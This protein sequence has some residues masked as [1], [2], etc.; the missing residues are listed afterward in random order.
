[1]K[2]L[3]IIP[4]RSGSKGLKDKN[5]KPLNGIP[6][7]A[8]TIKAAVDSGIFA[9]IHFSTD[10]QTYADIA[11]KYGAS[12]PFL[13]D[14]ILANDTASSWD[15]VK[16]VIANSQKLGKSFDAVM[17][18]QP[19]VPF[20]T[21]EDIRNAL[22]VFEEKKANAVVS[23]TDPPHSPLWSAPLPEDGNMKIFHERAQSLKARQTLEKYYALNGAIYL[24]DI[25]HLMEKSDIYEEGCFAY[26]M[27][28]ERS[29]DIDTQLDF[30]WCEFMAAR[31]KNF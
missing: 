5:I 14:A 29:F 9:E 11:E 24:T 10:S 6:L 4:A 21:A 1:M 27:P 25:Q 18:L 12:V 13:R 20:R 15:V 28:P 30:D 17:L 26:H 23:V 19:T 16:A 8:Y 7:C 31:G 22:A 3:A 2:I